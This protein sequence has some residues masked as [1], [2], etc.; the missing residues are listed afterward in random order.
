[1]VEKKKT[2]TKVKQRKNRLTG[3]TLGP[4]GSSADS[5]IIDAIKG[6]I[7]SVP[8][9]Y[10]NAYGDPYN[11][12]IDKAPG[13]R[14]DP[15]L[16]GAQAALNAGLGGVRSGLGAASNVINPALNAAS[17]VF[18]AGD[19][20]SGYNYLDGEQSLGDFAQSGLGAASSG[21]NAASN[22][23]KAGENALEPFLG[24]IDSVLNSFQSNGDADSQ[25]LDE[26]AK[27]LSSSGPSKADNF[28]W[29]NQ[30][31]TDEGVAE[32]RRRLGMDQN[33]RPS[34]EFQ[35]DDGFEWWYDG[36][37]ALE[38]LRRGGID[39]ERGLDKAGRA[40]N[41]FMSDSWASRALFGDKNKF[42]YDAPRTA[43]PLD[44]AGNA[45]DMPG[46]RY[47]PEW[48]A[49]MNAV[50]ADDYNKAMEEGN[51]VRGLSPQQEDSSGSGS[52]LNQVD[53]SA[54]LALMAGQ[55]GG[56]ATGGAGG[57]AM[58]LMEQL[59]NSQRGGAEGRYDEVLKF[60]G[61]EGARRNNQIDS[62][63][64]AILKQLQ[65]SDAKRRAGEDFYRDRR[66]GEFGELMGKMNAY[67]SAGSGRLADLG[68]DPQLYTSAVGQQMG[69]LLG[70]QMQSGND[71][72]NRMAMIGAE[73]AEGAMGRASA[74]M[75]K[76]RRSLD[77]SVASMMFQGSQTL[78]MELQ[79]I[80]DALMNKRIDAATAQQAINQS[81][82]K[83]QQSMMQ[84]EAIGQALGLQSGMGAV[85]GEQGYLGKFIDQ[86]LKPADS[87]EAVQIVNQDLIDQLGLPQNLIG[88]PMSVSQLQKWANLGKTTAQTN[89]MTFR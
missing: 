14:W 77:A 84:N 27:M 81:T 17:N 74:G 89:E 23:F 45:R 37:G 33:N 65:G 73:R 41:P 56:G 24:R 82:Q 59:A 62:D 36:E 61:T 83:A 85:L 2:P 16:G 35:K 21:L 40:L 25:R 48:A 53:L 12:L 18:K 67:Q 29:E 69:T 76:E 44:V 3:E 22:A 34:G 26:V 1:M 75:S 46:G 57:Q 32:L 87:P 42:D 9:A 6:A 19:Q 13:N 68:I 4:A 10:S 63:E 86:D 64:A 78:S 5:Q 8:G 71:L 58:S 51:P 43:G 66:G 15:T 80:N 55:G 30:V 50:G 79:S 70:A 11:N 7:K 72:M 28:S 52:G 20:E 49:A 31:A 47:G 54:L 38:N 60:L 88:Q 39:L